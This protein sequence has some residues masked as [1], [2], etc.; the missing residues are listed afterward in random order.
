MGSK[1]LQGVFDGIYM[2]THCEESTIKKDKILFLRL[3]KLALKFCK[4]E[5]CNQILSVLWKTL[6][7]YFWF[8]IMVWFHSF[9]GLDLINDPTDES[10]Y[11]KIK[12][13]DFINQYKS[14]LY[15]LQLGT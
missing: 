11:F 6:N 15:H 13:F 12:E 5:N 3:I 9:F 14:T 2:F 7:I 10:K 1:G 8:W 4:S